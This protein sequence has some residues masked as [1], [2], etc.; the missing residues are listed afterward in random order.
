[1]GFIVSHS[2]TMRGFQRFSLLP[3]TPTMPLTAVSARKIIPKNALMR[4]VSNL[5]SLG[6]PMT[7][8]RVNRT[9][10]FR[11]Y[12]LALTTSTFI[13]T[14]RTRHLCATSKVVDASTHDTRG[15]CHDALSTPSSVAEE[16][17]E[18]LLK[19]M[20]LDALPAPRA[21]GGLYKPVL[22]VGRVLYV[23]GH[24]PLGPDGVITGV[25]KTDSDVP[26]AKLS[27]AHTALAVLASVKS[28]LGSLDRIDSVVKV[29]GMVNCEPGFTNHPQVIDGFSEVMEEVFG[30]DCGVGV[31]SAVGMVLPNG[32]ATEVEC[33]FNLK[34]V[35]R[36]EKLETQGYSHNPAARNA[37]SEDTTVRL[38]VGGVSFATT[39]ESLAEA[40]VSLTGE[41]PLDVFLL[42]DRSGRPKGCGFVT[43][44]TDAADIL[45][46][47]VNAEHDGRV[48]RFDVGKQ[49]S[50]SDNQG[51]GHRA[52]VRH[53]NQ[54]NFG[55]RGR[56]ASG[57]VNRESHPP[58]NILFVGQLPF[59]MR[60]DELLEIFEGAVEARVPQNSQGIGK[61]FGYVE[62]ETVEEATAAVENYDGMSLEGRRCNVCFS[63]PR[64]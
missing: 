16:R 41:D 57:H 33:V 24:P 28:H 62:F 60:G 48:L 49:R 8:S 14:G 20:G 51:H 27:A 45:C 36:A 34:K 40:V 29:F 61:G 46:K 7:P 19:K 47:T 37:L 5:R 17:L 22:E 9:S 13:S 12:E 11:R 31:R 44:S 25:C 52:Q 58:S 21:P 64:W 53:Q 56:A 32:I 26:A 55:S 4:S 35:P 18:M 54:R 50:D 6:A 30:S 39:K 3:A 59:S 38:F 10:S 42:S 63:T 2:A 15:D 23:S 43:V 1:M